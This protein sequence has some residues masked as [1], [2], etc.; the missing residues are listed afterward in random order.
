MKKV[1]V[2]LTD[3]CHTQFGL[4]RS[5][6]SLG[7]GTIGAYL[8]KKFGKD[9]NVRLFTVYEDLIDGFKEKEPDIV[10]L[11][12]FG[13]NENLTV[14]TMSVIRRD[15]PNVLI[16]TGGANI[17]PFGA[18]DFS[19]RKRKIKLAEAFCQQQDLQILEK[20]PNCDYFTH[21]DG[22]LPFSLIVK[23]FIKYDYSR[24]KM[25]TNKA[26]VPGA[27]LVYENQ[28][29]FGGTGELLKSL[30]E[31]DSPYILGLYD[32]ILSKYDLVPQI[33]TDRGCPF[34]CGFCTIGGWTN[35]VIKHSVEWSK[36]E[37]L[38][39]KERSKIKILRIANSNFGLLRHDI[40]IGTFLKNL[41]D[42]TGYPSGIRVYSAA[43]G[44]NERVKNLMLLFGDMLPL[45][46]SFQ[47]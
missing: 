43:R 21:G 37:I 30:D 15:F 13:W 6:I 39:L 11:A 4:S 38:D 36:K 17:S 33:E 18:T 20:I 24:K 34:E 25:I 22:E 28:L 44:A 23:E 9:V 1:T 32:E 7:I 45:N 3:L 46:L 2:Y 29:I 42:E 5:S 40:E 19:N 8:I 47:R 27:S 10:G 14:K 12:N 41:R 16:V 31:F 26:T 35:A